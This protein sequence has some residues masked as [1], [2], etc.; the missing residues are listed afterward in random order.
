MQLNC[1]VIKSGNPPIS[2]LS[3]PYQGYPH[4]L[5][6]CLVPT[7]AQLIQFSE[8]PREGLEGSNYV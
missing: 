4:F 8:G 3:P 2:I 7:P 5:A 1:K 6:K